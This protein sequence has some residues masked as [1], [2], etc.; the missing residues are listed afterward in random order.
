[1]AIKRD[2]FSDIDYLLEK[3]DL[4]IKKTKRDVKKQTAVC[5]KCSINKIYYNGFCES[6]YREVRNEKEEAAV[7]K[8]WFS[9]NGYEY[10]YAEG[11]EP[12]LYARYRMA[13]ILGRPLE[14]G[15]RVRYKNGNK[16]DTS[17]SNLILSSNTDIDLA[18]LV[19][20]HCD[21]PFIDP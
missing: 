8:R 9:T 3:A 2:I 19:C 10:I 6:C 16:A 12:V 18:T 21:K 1:M 14:K 13:Q 7:G 5:K 4:V 11:M 20:P 17:D 15:E